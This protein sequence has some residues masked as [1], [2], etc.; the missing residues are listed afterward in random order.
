MT[1]YGVAVDSNDNIYV[2]G[3][4]GAIGTGIG[5]LTKL[6]KYGALVWTKTFEVRDFYNSYKT[7]GNRN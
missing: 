6:D 4:T 5:H 7:H 2:V 1:G 3:E